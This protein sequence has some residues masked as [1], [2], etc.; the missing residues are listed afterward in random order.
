MPRLGFLAIALVFVRGASKDVDCRTSSL[1]WDWTVPR[2]CTSVTATDRLLHTTQVQNIGASLPSLPDC[3]SVTLKYSKPLPVEFLDAVVKARATG[4][5]VVVS[6]TSQSAQVVEAMISW[7]TREVPAGAVSLRSEHGTLYAKLKE[8][9]GYLKD[10]GANQSLVTETSEALTLVAVCGEAADTLER[11]DAGYPGVSQGGCLSK[12]D[13]CWDNTR[14]DRPNC[15]YVPRGS[16]D[17]SVVDVLQKSVNAAKSY[18]AKISEPVAQEL[19]AQTLSL[20]RAMFSLADEDGDGNISQ[21]EC[22]QQS[23]AVFQ[24][25][26]FED[27]MAKV[28]SATMSLGLQELDTGLKNLQTGLEAFALEKTMSNI[29]RRKE[30]E[31]RDFHN[32]VFPRVC[33]CNS[34]CEMAASELVLQGWRWEAGWHSY[35]AGLLIDANVHCSPQTA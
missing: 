22:T 33:L 26:S 15:F 7:R 20:H 13:T 27:A 18:I 17:E 10:R 12:G 2:S 6:T 19:K 5:T 16:A 9:E 4:S 14:P 31:L 23:C 34:G 30:A 8:L 21:E 35:H 32:E 11:V 25:Q 1:N 3:K 28:E 24:E 29:Q